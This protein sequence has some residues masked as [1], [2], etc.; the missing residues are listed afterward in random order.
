MVHFT[1]AT[2]NDGRL[3]RQSAFV[4]YLWFLVMNLLQELIVL[5]HQL[6]MALRLSL[7]KL[8]TETQTD[9][10]RDL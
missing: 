8:G 6:I 7:L 10:Q 4:I 2:G 9:S 3:E 1:E 5:F